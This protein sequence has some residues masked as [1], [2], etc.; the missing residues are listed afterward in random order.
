MDITSTVLWLVEKNRGGQSERGADL[1]MQTFPMKSDTEL[2]DTIKEQSASLW[3]VSLEAF[4][5]LV[6]YP[7]DLRPL[8]QAS[9]DLMLPAVQH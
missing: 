8:L 5:C 4:L 1:E 3:S 7:G 9:E 6:H 2:Y